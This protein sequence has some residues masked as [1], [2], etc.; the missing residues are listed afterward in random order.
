MLRAL[1]H[2]TL[3][4]LCLALAGCSSESG[5]DGGAGGD[6]TGG[7]SGGA[8][9]VTSGGASGNDGGAGSGAGSN[10]GGSSGDAAT[11]DPC[12]GQDAAAPPLGSL[13]TLVVLGDSI[14]S[15]G[16]E[17]PFYPQV[18][19]QSLEAKYG[20]IEFYNH[21]SSGSTTAALIGQVNELPDTLPGP[22]AVVITSGANDLQAA[23]P[24]VLAGNDANARATMS[25]NIGVA[26]DA[27]LAPNR[28]GNAV[29]VFVYEANIYDASDGSGDLGELCGYG[30]IPPV[31]IG[32]ILDAWNGA[33]Q[34]PVQVRGQTLHDIR[35]L[36][37]GHGLVSSVSWFVD[38][39]HPNSTGHAALASS[40][41]SLI[42]GSAPEP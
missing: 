35:S 7:T 38:C 37:Q 3:T 6:T 26:L 10:T 18:L 17:A 15:G 34:M 13:G 4:F 31:P 1:F 33:I 11:C 5:S 23:L 32:A 29:N 36:F 2:L 8:G 39:G 21:A 28:F 40:F 27:L 22:V 24:D 41:Q 30:D 19:R 14:G 12:P 42:A 16:G 25:Q 9:T 20:A